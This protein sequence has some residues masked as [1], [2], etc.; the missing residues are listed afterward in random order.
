LDDPLADFLTARWGL[1]TR[2]VRRSLFVPNYHAT[3]PL[4]TATLRSL[5]DELVAAAGLPGISDKEPDSVL[6]SAGVRTV[7]GI[8]VS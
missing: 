7:F 5:D 4:Q 2:W 8:P 3:W 1:H 6:W